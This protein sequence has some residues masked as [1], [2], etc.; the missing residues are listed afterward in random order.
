MSKSALARS[1]GVSR[2]TLY[3][4]PKQPKK[5]ELLKEHI[6][7]ALEEHPAYGHRRLALHLKTNKKRILRVMHKYG[8][9]PRIRRRRPKY[10]RKTSQSGIPNRIRGICPIAPN[11]IWAGDFTYL[12]YAGRN[13][14]L[15]TAIDLFTREVVG[16]QIGVHHTSQ[17]VI[18]VL[19]ESLRKR[20]QTPMIFHSDQGSE[21]ASHACILW[22][23][24]HRIKPS[25][26]PKGKPWHNGGQ[27]S[28]YS[29]FKLEFGKAS[30]FATLESLI[31]GIGRH[32]HYYNT[33]R[34][35]S[36]L[37]MPPREFFE[38]ENAKNQTLRMPN[39]IK[40]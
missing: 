27:E 39:V 40:V 12:W 29:S 14:Y 9:E 38:R 26:S 8:I 7:H 36:A 35:H 33:E 5:D 13:I 25:H 31:E 10:G 32:I 4:V 11:V 24:S 3:Y 15:A 17:L 28:F 1:L 16:W 18:D 37:K 23:V 21:Y 30:R 20:L 34:I 19:Q 2:S 22:L 6:I